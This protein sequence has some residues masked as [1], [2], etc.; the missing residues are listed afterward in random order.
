MNNNNNDYKKV[1]GNLLHISNQIKIYHWQTFSFARHKATDEL[2]ADF[3]SLMDRFVEVLNG[4]IIRTTKTK[5]ISVDNYN[6]TLLDISDD[7]GV[8]ILNI[9]IDL[10]KS[11]LFT[12]VI[13]DNSDLITIRDEMIELINKHY[14]LFTMK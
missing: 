13:G 8:S 2:Y 12:R 1:V 11:D 4:N 9:T 3:N 14:Y 10:L 6:V 7:N 5:R